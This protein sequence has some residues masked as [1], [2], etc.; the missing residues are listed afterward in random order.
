MDA[1]R[2]RIWSDGGRDRCRQEEMQAGTASHSDAS[3]GSCLWQMT[4]RLNPNYTKVEKEALS[5]S[6]P[7]DLKVDKVA[8]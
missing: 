8:K 4:F 2:N 7:F 5:I 1:G 6:K 3:P